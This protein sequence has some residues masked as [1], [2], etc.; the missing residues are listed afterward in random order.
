MFKNFF[1]AVEVHTPPV[2][3]GFGVYSG[4]KFTLEVLGVISPSVT[5]FD[6]V[7]A[8]SVGFLYMFEKHVRMT[9]S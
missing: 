9:T 1:K 7:S 5:P 6:T 3:A 8:L 4:L 2:L